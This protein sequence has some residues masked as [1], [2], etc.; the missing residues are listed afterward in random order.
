MAGADERADRHRPHRKPP[1]HAEHAGQHVVRDGALEQRE[2]GNVVDAVRG[3]DHREQSE[4]R[5]EVRKRRN[6]HDRRA[7][8]DERP[9]ERRRES[10]PAKRHRPECAQQAAGADRGRQV[11]DLRCTLVQHLVGGDDDQDVQAS[12]HEGLRG[13]QAHEQARAGDV[14]DRPESLPDRPSGAG[15]TPDD[16]ARDRHAGKQGGRH[17]ESSRS[18]RKDHSDV[19]ERDQQ[20]RGER[21]EQGAEA[22]DRRRRTV[23]G[24][25]L[26][27]RSRQRRQQRLKCRPEESRADTDRSRCAEHEEPVAHQRARCRDRG[28][29]PPRAARHRGGI[30]HAGIDR[31]ATMRTARSAQPGAAARARRYRPQWFR[32]DRTQT[33]PGRRSGPTRPR[34]SRPRPTRPGGGRRAEPR[35]QEQRTPGADETSGRVSPAPA[36]HASDAARAPTRHGPCA[37]QHGGA[38]LQ[39]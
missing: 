16:V 23:G 29:P 18:G 4:H 5:H 26:P 19:D 12:A 10:L 31:R 21:A 11:P 13:D 9:A 39:P 3:A 33:P 36:P 15:R 32:R 8:E 20:T 17:E 22:L 37:S 30:A 25:Q 27:G 7:P 34:P 38:R 14:A 6:Q 1:G 35:H 2:P 28:E 24:D